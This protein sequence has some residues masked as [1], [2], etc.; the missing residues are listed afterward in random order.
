MGNKEGKKTNTLIDQERNRQLRESEQAKSVL[1]PNRDTEYDWSQG[2]RGDITGGYKGLIS[3]EGINAYSGGVTGS[4][5]GGGGGGGFAAPKLSLDPRFKALEAGYKPLSKGIHNAFGGYSEFAEGTGGVTDEM[6]DR[7]RGLGVFDDYAKTGG[8]TGADIA[9]TRARGIA[10]VGAFYGN[11]KN[12]IARRNAATGG[13]GSTGMDTATARLAR[14]QAIGATG[15]A[16]DTELGLQGQ[17]RSNKL[18]GAQALSG[19]ETNYAKMV[20]EG[21][22]AGLAGLTDIGKFGYGGLEGIAARSQAINDA[23]ARSAAA[24]SNARASAG[25]AQAETDAANQLEAQKYRDKMKLAGLSGL[26]GIYGQ[27]PA[28]LARYDDE[29]YRNRALTQS[30]QGSNLNLRSQYNPNISGWDRALQIGGIAAGVAGALPTGAVS[31][32]GRRKQKIA[33][34]GND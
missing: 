5:G 7:I 19:A 22:L 30:G 29:L 3:G 21:R 33:P 6:R 8:Y 9:N 16:R 15:A 20:Q 26:E 28:E 25:R 4:A 18:G 32:L 13:Y 34:I 24:A 10:P 17:I 11:L 12:E 27:T 31:K 1:Q 2:I 14:E 23:N